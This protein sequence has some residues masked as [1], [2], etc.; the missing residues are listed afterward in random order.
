MDLILSSKY[1]DFLKNRSPVEFL[2]G[3]TFAG[4]T[5]VGI[6]KFML[7]VAESRQ[8]LHIISG[9]DTGTIE[10]NI[11][12]KDLGIKDIFCHICCFIHQAEKKR[13]IYL[14]MIINLAGKKHL[15]GSMD[16]YTSTRSTLRTWNM[17]ENLL[18]GAII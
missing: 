5:T 14:G 8:K 15:A 10:K 1:K 17:S 12:N 18:C 7:M 4:K 2:E 3:T 9:L 13:F 6:F 16:A 11:I